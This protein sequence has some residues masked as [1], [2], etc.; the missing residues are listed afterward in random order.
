[1]Y[2]KTIKDKKHI[3]GKKNLPKN[4]TLKKTGGDWWSSLFSNNQSEP[5]SIY[6]KMID[7]Y[8][9]QISDLNGAIKVL[10]DKIAK[11]EIAK[12]SDINIKTENAK[13]A[14]LNKQKSE[15]L[16][17]ATNNNWIPKFF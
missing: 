7:K 16:N 15:A 13:L 1:M 10:E 11:V 3:K 8:K 2:K 14:E 12:Q 4:K 6:D 17:S 5:V 9:K